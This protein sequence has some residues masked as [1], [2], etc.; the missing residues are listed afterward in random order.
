ML[1][2]KEKMPKGVNTFYR[3]H[4]KTALMYFDQTESLYSK[5]Y[6]YDG[7]E[8]ESFCLMEA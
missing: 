8:I 6:S 2:N 3:H 1:E 7:C 5:W 4:I